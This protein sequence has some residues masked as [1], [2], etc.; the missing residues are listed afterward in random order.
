M[1]AP[2]VSGLAAMIRGYYPELTAV[3]VK[4][5]IEESAVQP[6]S[7][8][9][10]MKP[11]TKDEEVPFNLLSKTGGIINAYKAILSADTTK[12]AASAVLKTPVKPSNIPSP[13]N[14]KSNK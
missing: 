9:T 13:K 14:A 11:G 4:K 10:V 12:T 3:Q 8:V 6:E 1:S 5:I 2:I 7:A